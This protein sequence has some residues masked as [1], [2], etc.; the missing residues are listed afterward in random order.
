M[1]NK[2]LLIGDDIRRT[3]GVANILKQIILHLVS[4]FDFVQLAC[5]NSQP[6]L[7]IVD[8]SESVSKITGHTQASVRLHETNGYSSPEQLRSTMR[9]ESPDAV[10]IMTDPHRYDWLFEIEHEVRTVC[11]LLYYHV[12]DNDPYPKFLKSIYN[13]CDWVGCISITTKKC[14]ETIC[15]EHTN[16]THVPH[17]INTKTY[18]QHSDK[19]ITHNRVDFLGQDYK[20]V[21]FCN[22]A[23]TSRKQL[24]NLI[25]GFSVF[26][27]TSVPECDREGV[28]LLLHT[29]P[30][31]PTGP[32]INCLLDD[33]FPDLPVFLSSE[34]VTE[35]VLNNMY[36]LAHCT[37]NIASTEGFGLST[38]ESVAA[39]TP[40]I[41]SH[42]GGLKDQYDKRW[43]EKIEPTIRLLSGTQKT[44]YIYSDICSSIDISSAIGKMYSR[45]SCGDIDMSDSDN[46]LKT[47]NFTTGQMCKSIGQGIHHTIETFT[48]R[49]QFKFTK[50]FAE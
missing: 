48:P 28:A 50:V 7:S 14:I 40:I 6:N 31:S 38:L 2:I 41:I 11:P 16:Y 36:N 15:P 4:D 18:H 34:T 42:T 43:A 27:E 46:F 17:G 24:A 23:N 47:N 12:W 13:S 8:V 45:I 20:F 25:E 32:D 37:I 35:S 33:L 26:Y 44:P 29:N 39:K 19:Q 3:T 21:L 10:V 9:M 49:D 1:K 5:G 22:N 30:D